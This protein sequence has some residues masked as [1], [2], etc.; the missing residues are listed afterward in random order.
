MESGARG[1]V[2]EEQP[3]L[4]SLL[5]A[6][7]SQQWAAASIGAFLF[8]LYVAAEMFGEAH[9]PLDPGF[10]AVAGGIEASSVLLTATLIYVSFSIRKARSLLVLAAGYQFAGLALIAWGLSFPG[11]FGPWGLLGGC[12][13]TSLY[14]GIV[15]DLSPG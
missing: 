7:R 8:V 3:I 14:L 11:S 6:S 12:V 2:A 9:W 5:P 15:A 4:L 13:Q 10:A 1:R